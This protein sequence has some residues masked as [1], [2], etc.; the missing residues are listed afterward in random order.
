MS[1]WREVKIVVTARVRDDVDGD[2]VIA[3][4]V[5]IEADGLDGAQTRRRGGYVLKGAAAMMLGEGPFD[6]VTGIGI[7]L[8]QKP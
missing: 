1:V 7:I 5:H 4:H 8:D 2:G 3:D 6:P